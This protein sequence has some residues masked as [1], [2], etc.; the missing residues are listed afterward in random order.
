MVKLSELI[1]D[2]IEMKIEGEPEHNN[3]ARQNYRARIAVLRSQID[4][5]HADSAKRNEE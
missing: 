4:E 2:F 1:E 3:W 5:L